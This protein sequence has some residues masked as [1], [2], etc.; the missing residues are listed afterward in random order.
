MSII[1]QAAKRL[2]ELRRSGV[3]LTER[4]PSPEAR[5][6]PGSAEAAI[7]RLMRKV[8]DAATAAAG[9]GTP[10]ERSGE[11][12]K[13]LEQT[14]GRRSHQVHIDLARLAA[15]GFVTPDA[16]RSQLA[17]EFRVIKRPLLTNVQGKSAAPV[18]R[19]NLI[20]VTSS[21][22]GEGKTFVAINLALSIAMELDRTVL[23]VDAD[24]SRPSL[25]ERLGLPPSRGLLDVLTDGALE[26]PDVLLRTNV[27]RLSL[28]PAGTAH[29]RATELLA[30]DAMNR[31][32]DEL[33]TR[34][35]DRILIFDAPPL[36]PSTESRVLATHMGQVVV[37]VEAE[38]TPQASVT[39]ALA[40]I[41]SCPVVMTMLNKV[42]HSRLGAYYGYYGQYGY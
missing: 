26:L 22:P 11:G 37:V 1:E 10:D 2:E 28:L 19:A 25:L 27:E 39:Q 38:R 33:A 4:P 6:V 9:T 8:G 31:L 14:P 41:E 35:P 18:A 5:M 20:M 40:T 29:A 3:D 7:P 17:D 30:S 16:P 21:V 36:L 23:L 42:P 32:L 15:G 12:E 13:A 34:Y 24:V